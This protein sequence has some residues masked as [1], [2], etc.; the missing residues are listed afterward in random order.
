MSCCERIQ[1]Y[2]NQT[3]RNATDWETIEWPGCGPVISCCIGKDEAKQIWQDMLDAVGQT[4][5]FPVLCNWNQRL[6][7]QA[8][9]EGDPA[10][11]IGE[12]EQLDLEAWRTTQAQAFPEIGSWS[13]TVSEI[14]SDWSWSLE[15][16]ESRRGNR[17]EAED[18][19]MAQIMAL[20]RENVATLVAISKNSQP[21][22]SKLL[23]F[24]TVCSWHVPAL[25]RFGGRY[26]CP[27]PAVHAAL[28][29]YWQER[30]GANLQKIEDY[31]LELKLSVPPSEPG[32]AIKLAVDQ[33]LYCP[34]RVLAVADD[35]AEFATQ[36]LKSTTWTFSWD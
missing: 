14:E 4:G 24:P 23:F 6:P 15:E 9:S 33:Y 10:S 1:S 28:L 29:K 27:P 32:E 3:R 19:L 2:L 11:I 5:C 18:P 7:L 12:A 20:T 16:Q 22:N 36:I 17:S 21:G 31:S 8:W 35:L 30:Y 13:E 34:D 25:V 26:E